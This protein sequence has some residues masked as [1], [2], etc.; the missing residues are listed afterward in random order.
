[1]FRKEEQNENL[2]EREP[3]SELVANAIKEIKG[4][5]DSDV[6]VGKQIRT[7]D[8]KVI[9]PISRVSVGFVAG[10]GEYNATTIDAKSPYAGGSGAG[11]SIIPMGLVVINGE[12]VKM[13]KVTQSEPLLKLIDIIPDV[14][15]TAVEKTKGKGKNNEKL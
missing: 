5:I 7:P 1:M 3:I 4:M 8:D 11:F 14:V 9:V 15:K 12:D 10:G 6:V 13:I 2:K